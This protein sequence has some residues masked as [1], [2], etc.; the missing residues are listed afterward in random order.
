MDPRL[1]VFG[2]CC[3][4][5]SLRVVLPLIDGVYRW[6]AWR[7]CSGLPLVIVL[8]FWLDVDQGLYRDKKPNPMRLGLC[9]RSNDVIEPMLKPQWWVS[10]AGMA[11]R[12]ADAVRDGSLK[13]VPSIHEYVP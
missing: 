13:I 9:S 11:K 3:F 2:C 12:A 8:L 5:A 1:L 6:L 7:H 4:F 10:C